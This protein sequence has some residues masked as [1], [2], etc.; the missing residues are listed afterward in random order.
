MSHKNK[1]SKYENEVYKKIN[2]S[3]IESLIVNLGEYLKGE[4]LTF[5]AHQLRKAYREPKGRRYSLEIRLIALLLY[6][7]GPKAHKHLAKIFSLPSKISSSK[8]LMTMKCLPGFQDEIFEAIKEHLKYMHLHDKACCLMIDEISLK[9]NLQYDR[10]NDIIVGYED[11]MLY[12]IKQTGHKCSCIF[13]TRY[14]I[15]LE[16]TNWLCLHFTSL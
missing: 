12:Q 15:K 5:V 9:S 1:V 6:N 11:F 7:S 4:C 16:P 3:D 8:W 2:T 10:Y 14:S 13:A